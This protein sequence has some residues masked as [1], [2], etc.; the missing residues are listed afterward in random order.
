V[1]KH[2][3]RCAYDCALV[4]GCAV[5]SESIAAKSAGFSEVYGVEISPEYVEIAK[6]RCAGAPGYYFDL[7]DG[8]KLPYAEAKFSIIFSGHIIEHTPN[9]ATYLA[10][11]L[12]VLKKGG[13][14]FMEFPTRY[15]WRE[16]HTRE[17]SGEWLPEPFRTLV[18]RALT[19][20]YSPLAPARK[21]N[22]AAIAQTL[23]P[24]SVWQIRHY[25]RECGCGSSKIVAPYQPLPG[26]QRL[27]IKKQ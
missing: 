19:S 1:V 15:H 10:E 22:Y 4:S 16:L 26:F 13:W 20:R 9:P 18:Y 27:L 5:G 25:L 3:D 12:R 17:I 14:I 24:I 23:K 2:I 11:L 21:K 8:N 6:Q 7:Y